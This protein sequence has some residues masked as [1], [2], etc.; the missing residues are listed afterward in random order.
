[1]KDLQKGRQQTGQIGDAKEVESPPTK[2]IQR[3]SRFKKDYKRMK[4]RN[5][6]MGLLKATITTLQNE[7]VLD[8]KH[9]NHQ[10]E[11]KWKKSFDCHIQS[12][13]V[14]I[15]RVTD[16]ALILQATG[17]HSDLFK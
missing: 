17:T 3:T 15:C 5:A 2:D 4:S 8:A 12:D 1:M 16:D 10:L 6:D 7:G 14:L 13:W 9:Q 11:G